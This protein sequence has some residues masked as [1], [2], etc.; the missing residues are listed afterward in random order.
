MIGAIFGLIGVLGAAISWFRTYWTDKQANDKNARYLAIRV[1]CVLD[2]FLED[3]AYVVKDKGISFG[4]NSPGR[5]I[6]PI[7]VD[8]RAISKVEF[9]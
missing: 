1:V 6:F 5:P 9:F 3:C 8:W 7:D 4:E 2:K